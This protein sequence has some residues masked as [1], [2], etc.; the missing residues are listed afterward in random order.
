MV[1]TRKM[2]FAEISWHIFMKASFTK[3]THLACW[4]TPQ[5][6]INHGLCPN[7]QGDFIPLTPLIELPNPS[8][9]EGRPSRMLFGLE[10]CLG[11]RF[12][13]SVNDK[14]NVVSIK[15]LTDSKYGCLNRFEGFP[16]QNYLYGLKEC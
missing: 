9:F 8:L 11:F 16:Y 12:D 4:G 15:E 6:P 13:E 5:T 3:G 14:R 10:L 2:Q 7:P 1:G